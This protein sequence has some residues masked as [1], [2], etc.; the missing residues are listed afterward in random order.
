MN[1]RW[2]RGSTVSWAP[3]VCSFSSPPPFF[4]NVMSLIQYIGWSSD[5]SSSPTT[6]G[7]GVPN[8]WANR[9]SAAGS[10]GKSRRMTKPSARSALSTRCHESTGTSPE[11]SPVKLSRRTWS[12]RVLSQTAVIPIPS[13]DDSP[14]V[15]R[16]VIL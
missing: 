12:V 3:A 13:V 2:N 1:S 4:W 8:C 6:R 15:G 14:F 10:T 7:S 5:T 11:P 9:T 16:I